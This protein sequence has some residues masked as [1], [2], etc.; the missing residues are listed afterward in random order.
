MDLRLEPA[1]ERD[2]AW[3]DQ[4]RR[5]AYRDLFIATWGGWDEARHA[6]HFAASWERGHV[7]LVHAGG[8]R[9][10]MLQVFTEPDVLRIGEIQIHPAHQGQGIGTRLLTDVLARAEEQGRG[11]ALSTGLH[12]HGAVRLYERRGFHVVDRT[13]THVHMTWRPSRA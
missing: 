1:A 6:R 9:V 3:L 12:N 13:A 5:A 11:V 10:G 7:Q 8:D 2:R 4:L